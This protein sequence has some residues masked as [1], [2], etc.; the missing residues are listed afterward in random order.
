V[1]GGDL[2]AHGGGKCDGRRR[3]VVGGHTRGQR[4]GGR[5]DLARERPACEVLE[6]ENGS[7]P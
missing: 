1:G 2:A 5:G 6:G 7:A 3:G 4:G